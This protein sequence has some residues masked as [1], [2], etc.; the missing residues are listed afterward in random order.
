MEAAVVALQDQ[1]NGVLIKAFLNVSTK[2]EASLVRMKQFS[3]NNLPPYM[4]PDR[5]AFLPSLPK[6]STNK[7]DYQKLKAL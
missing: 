3:M 7:I 4:V 1:D 6:T 5:F 2:E